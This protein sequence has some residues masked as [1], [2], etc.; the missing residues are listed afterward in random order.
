M[1]ISVITA[2]YNRSHTIARAINSVTSQ[3]Y[4]DVEHIIIDGAS[5][6]GTKEIIL[7]L[8]SKNQK[9]ISEPD[10]GIYDALNKGIN[11]STGDIVCFLHSDDIFNNEYVLSEVASIFSNESVDVVYGDVIFFKKNDVNKIKRRYNSKL[12]TKKNLA[13]GFMPAH[14]A[15]F[16][17]KSIYKEIGCFNISYKIAGDY[18]FLCRLVNKTEYVFKKVSN[19]YVRMQLGGISTNNFKN[20]MILN[21]EVY[22][23]CNLNNINTNYFKLSFKYFLKIKELF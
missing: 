15:M 8:S 11:L 14:P 23:A 6:D 5:N 13:S 18:D 3:D 4:Y 1:R 22:K 21:K 2:V 20:K 10:L 7:K 16:I 17:K 19:I 9:F 12:L